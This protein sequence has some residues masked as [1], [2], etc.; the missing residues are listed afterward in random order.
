MICNSIRY[1]AHIMF[2]QTVKLSSLNPNLS[3]YDVYWSNMIHCKYVRTS[4]KI[5]G[6]VKRLLLFDINVLPSSHSNN[7]PLPVWCRFRKD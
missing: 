6:D 4:D 3:V 7:G 5:N 1:Y 2:E